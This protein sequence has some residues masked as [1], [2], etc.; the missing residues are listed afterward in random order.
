MVEVRG[1]GAQRAHAAPL[2]RAMARACHDAVA[3]AS[4]RFHTRAE[5][6]GLELKAIQAYDNSLCSLPPSELLQLASVR[7]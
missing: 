2:T 6:V 7:C 5:L 4:I 1:E 3:P